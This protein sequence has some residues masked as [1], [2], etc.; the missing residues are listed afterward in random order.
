MPHRPSALYGYLISALASLAAAGL[1]CAQEDL[2]GLE[3]LACKRAVAEVAPS[4]VRIETL[5]GAEQVAGQVL[6]SGPST[7]LIVSADGL[8]ISSAFAFAGTPAST[9]VTL[10]SGERMPAEI[11]A[12]DHS[13][14]LVLLKIAVSQ[15][16]PVP[17]PVPRGELAVGQWTI[18]VG[19]A[20]DGTAP[21]VS[22]GI[23]SATQRVWG[24]AVQTDAKVSPANYGGPLLDIHGRVIGVLVPLSPQ[25]EGVL[26]GAEWY[27]SGIGFAVPLVDIQRV[28]PQLA[29][30][31][32]V[33]PGLLGIALEGQ[34][35][36]TQPAKIAACAPQSPARKAGLQ[37]GDTIVEV[38][39]RP[40]TRQSELRH[41]LGPR[42]AGERINLV[43]QRGDDE[44]VALSVELVATIPPYQRPELGILPL[45]PPL[46]D[47]QES[48]VGIRYVFP[49]SPAEAA[50]VR[51]GDRLMAM[52]GDA[53]ADAAALRDLIIRHDPGQTVSLRLARGEVQ[54]TL[55]VQL[56]RQSVTVPDALPPAHPPLSAAADRPPVGVVEVQIPEA[57]NKCLALVPE[58]Y[59]PGAAYGLLVWLPAPGQFEQDSWVQAWRPQATEHDLIVLAP[60]PVDP[61]RWLP[62]EI[63]FIRKS[64][65]DVMQRYHIDPARVVCYGS[66]AGAAMAYYVAFAHRD[67]VR[68]IVAIEAP[69]PTRLAAATAEPTQP[70]AIYS[71]VAEESPV[72][73]RV[74]AGLRLLEQR[75]FPVWNGTYPGAVREPDAAALDH[76]L[77]WIDAL[78]RI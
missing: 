55:P 19:R 20:V 2:E 26:A 74:Q 45:R 77:R 43:V 31:H 1:L 23:L 58:T 6:G 47:S 29:Q 8:I 12:R 9:L 35:I 30:G 41:A 70:L 28:L 16:L 53:I 57:V 78:D 42:I 56:G 75:A 71:L 68:G 4:V 50:G 39:G 14:M 37:A 48:G 76:I 27:D 22:V 62:T 21:Y 25:E 66:Q 24:R 11:V 44:R 33:D 59:D 60:Q 46:P 51:P 72:A 65:D 49:N 7:G 69:L 36:Y 3:E 38:D 63:E 54:E 52:D 5:A 40:I 10:A 13:R 64:I 15:P 34:D 67:V 17:T 61:Q 18:A 73:D 32:D